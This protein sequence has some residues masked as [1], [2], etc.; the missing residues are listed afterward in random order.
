MTVNDLIKK[1]QSLPKDTK[2]NM[3]SMRNHDLDNTPNHFIEIN[4]VMEI[5]VLIKEKSRKVV[6]LS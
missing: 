2:K 5:Y 4:S 3:I 1:L 6:L